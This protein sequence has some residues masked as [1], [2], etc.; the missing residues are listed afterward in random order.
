MLDFFDRVRVRDSFICPVFDYGMMTLNG[1]IENTF[2]M[3]E[4]KNLDPVQNIIDVF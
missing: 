2:P 1:C 3:S 4:F